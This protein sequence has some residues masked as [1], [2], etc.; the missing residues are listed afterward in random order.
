MAHNLALLHNND[1]L[2]DGSPG[3]GGGR[4]GVTLSPKDLT[5]DVGI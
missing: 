4:V 5:I 1:G 3:E 2:T